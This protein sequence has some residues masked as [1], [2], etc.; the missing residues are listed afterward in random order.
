MIFSFA[1]ISQYLRIF[2][3]NLVSSLSYWTCLQVFYFC[4]FFSL[5]MG[6]AKLNN[7]SFFQTFLALFRRDLM[8]RFIIQSNGLSWCQLS[9]NMK[10]QFIFIFFHRSIEIVFALHSAYLILLFFSPNNQIS[11]VCAC[12]IFVIFYENL[13]LLFLLVPVC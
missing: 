6:Q 9:L 4:W 2:R 1:I 5:D 12:E 11:H 8:L 13:H 7:F 10:I 3:I